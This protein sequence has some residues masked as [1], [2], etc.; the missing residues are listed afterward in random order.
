MSD[1]IKEHFQLYKKHKEEYKT[2]STNDKVIWVW[3][4]CYDYPRLKKSKNR[5]A[6]LWTE[7]GILFADDVPLAINMGSRLDRF[8]VHPIFLDSL[9]EVS[10]IKRYAKEVMQYLEKRGMAR[11]GHNPRSTVPLSLDVLKEIAENKLK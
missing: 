1:I 7:Q 6:S 5:S 4:N 3:D 11:F 2:A 10:Y 9:P 8:Y